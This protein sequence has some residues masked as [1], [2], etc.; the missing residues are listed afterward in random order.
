MPNIVHIDGILKVQSVLRRDPMPTEGFPSV[1]TAVPATIPA[2]PSLPDKAPPMPAAVKPITPDSPD[3]RPTHMLSPPMQP[4]FAYTSSG[5][6]SCSQTHSCN[7]PE[8]ALN[9]GTRGAV[10]PSHS[11]GVHAECRD[12]SQVL[13]RQTEEDCRPSG[14]SQAGSRRGQGVP[15]QG[16][17]LPPMPAAHSAG[18]PSIPKGRVGKGVA[19]PASKTPGVS[20]AWGKHSMKSKGSRPPN[21]VPAGAR[22]KPAPGWN[23]DFSV[24]YTDPVSI[25]DQERHMSKSHLGSAKQSQMPS[26]CTALQLP[27]GQSAVAQ[28]GPAKQ[29]SS[30]GSA[31]GAS[32]A[33][34]PPAVLWTHQGCR[35]LAAHEPCAH[36][37]DSVYTNDDWECSLQSAQIGCSSVHSRNLDSAQSYLRPL[38]GEHAGSI[39]LC[40]QTELDKA[41]FMRVKGAPIQA[42]Q[43]QS[44][45]LPPL[46]TALVL[47]QAMSVAM[48]LTSSAASFLMHTSSFSPLR[49]SQL[50]SSS[51][52]HPSFAHTSGQ[53]SHGSIRQNPWAECKAMLTHA[54][55]HNAEAGQQQADR[56]PSAQCSHESSHD[57]SHDRFV[58]SNSPVC[59]APVKGSWQRAT[60]QVRSQ[61]A[62]SHAHRAEDMQSASAAQQ[63]RAQGSRA[64]W[65]KVTEDFPEQGNKAVVAHHSPAS[66]FEAA[67]SSKAGS[68]SGS[69]VGVAAAC[70]TSTCKP[71][72]SLNAAGCSPCA[73]FLA[74]QMA[75]KAT[76]PTGPFMQR[77]GSAVDVED[78][79]VAAAAE[80]A[81][82]AAGTEA[83]SCHL[84]SSL[85]M[86]TDCLARQPWSCE[87]TDQL[88][89]RTPEEILSALNSTDQA[90]LAAAKPLQQVT[91]LPALE[92]LQHSNSSA[93]VLDSQ[94]IQTKL[95]CVSRS[96]CIHIPAHIDDDDLVLHDS[97]SEAADMSYSQPGVTDTSFGKAV[98]QSGAGCATAKGCTS[99]GAYEALCMHVV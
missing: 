88:S 21:I 43:Q 12:P 52:S 64:H 51:P 95:G 48:P 99:P 92:P 67:S 61:A 41:S 40:G 66:S 69:A 35:P 20:S 86:L 63:N 96:S 57:V 23:D 68:K 19:H 16:F 70:S 72:S 56:S 80:A 46:L 11:H 91:D 45:L 22:S 6:F 27:R 76:K 97:K 10:V 30:V 81:S 39:G 94:R 83:A 79:R 36:C 44:Q 26:G 77:P 31:A 55:V 98:Y 87:G 93:V 2:L 42:G 1:A 24:Q 53:K 4:S 47:D 32:R 84:A 75:S 33:N 18:S 28:H 50:D 71:C 49:D 60:A 14:I 65:S 78:A 89:C 37:V 73:S 13:I 15:A 17:G 74:A 85:P 90:F 59:T 5:H 9:K 34:K 38:K 25:K 82:I 7:P 8:Q 54:E 62:S 58:S 3:I 29:A